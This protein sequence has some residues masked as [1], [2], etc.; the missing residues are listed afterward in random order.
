V[1]NPWGY[2]SGSWNAFVALKVVSVSPNTGSAG[3]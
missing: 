2:A 1:N 3:G